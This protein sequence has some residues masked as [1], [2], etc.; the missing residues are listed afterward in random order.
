MIARTPEIM[1]P[2]AKYLSRIGAN[3]GSTTGG[4]KALAAKL[5]GALGGRPK[6]KRT[7]G[8]IKKRRREMARKAR[9]NNRKRK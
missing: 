9:K 2:I 7:Q 1:D 6:K 4:A 3:G 8:E 5:N